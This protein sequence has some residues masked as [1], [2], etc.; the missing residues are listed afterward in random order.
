MITEG[1]NYYDVS[2][3]NDGKFSVMFGQ[4]ANGSWSTSA[5]TWKT[6]HLIPSAR[7]A[8]AEPA[9]NFKF[10]DVPG[11]EEPLDLSTYLTGQIEFSWRQGSLSFLVDPGYEHWAM[12]RESM[13]SVLH[14]KK[15]QMRLSDDSNFIYTGYFTVGEWTTGETNSTIS[16]SYELEPYRYK[17]SS[18]GYV[19]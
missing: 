3:S 7:Q 19:I 6:W 11:A 4:Y 16:I 2:N 14:G 1:G 15:I 17:I 12:I 13:M 5:D 8:I 18:G 9:P 10:V